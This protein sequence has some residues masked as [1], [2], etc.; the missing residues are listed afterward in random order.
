MDS[1][2]GIYRASVVDVNDPEKRKRY[3]VRVD[4]I[5]PQEVE[6]EA[7]PWA[8][9]SLFGG[10][11]FGDLPA[12]LRDDKVWV[13]F[14]QGDRRF[15]VIMGGILTE[16]AGVPDAPTEITS[17]YPVT[18]ERWVRYDRAG[19]IVVM[20]PLPEE[21]YI[22]IRTGGGGAEIL[23]SDNHLVVHVMVLEEA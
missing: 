6:I 8:E 17:D 22:L 18:Q 1:Y 11:F 3:R 9:F 10:K 4:A 14:E 23:L 15:P 7:C 2:P 19:N 12:F 20:S 13:M 21:R 5:H 16:K